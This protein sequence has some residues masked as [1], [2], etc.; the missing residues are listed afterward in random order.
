MDFCVCF[1]VPPWKGHATTHRALQREPIFLMCS[2][3]PRWD[4][5][6]W[7]WTTGLHLL[8]CLSLQQNKKG[9][10]LLESPLSFQPSPKLAEDEIPEWGNPLSPAASSLWAHS[11]VSK[12]LVALC[13]CECSRVYLLSGHGPGRRGKDLTHVYNQYGSIPSVFSDCHKGI[14]GKNEQCLLLTAVIILRACQVVS[15]ALP[16]IRHE[17]GSGCK[18]MSCVRKVQEVLWTSGKLWRKRVSMRAS[19]LILISFVCYWHWL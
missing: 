14:P 9:K 17:L 3:M 18:T 10:Q 1:W 2:D 11:D 4:G 8:K 7:V 15:L 6:V 16:F 13:C 5:S 12:W 19:R